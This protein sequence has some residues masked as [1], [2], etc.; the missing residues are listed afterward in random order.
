MTLVTRSPHT[1]MQD[2]LRRETE[3]LKKFA[4]MLIGASKS[5]INAAGNEDLAN[6]AHQNLWVFG[7]VSVNL[8]ICYSLI[9]YLVVF[10]LIS[11]FVTI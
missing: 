11:I 2:I 1:S 5:L 4:P 3:H 7:C 9:I 6:A 8:N 10:Q